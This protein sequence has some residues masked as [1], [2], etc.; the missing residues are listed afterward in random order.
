MRACERAFRPV[1]DRLRASTELRLR[2]SRLFMRY[3]RVKEDTVGKGRTVA[4]HKYGS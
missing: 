4:R 1:I 3:Y 2:A